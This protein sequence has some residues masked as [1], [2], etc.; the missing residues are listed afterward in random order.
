V[1][2]KIIIVGS[3]ASGVHFAL[4]L[5]RKGYHVTMLDVGNVGPKVVNPQD[6]FN[7]LKSTLSDPVDY[8]L[9]EE[10]QAVI[11]P[12]FESEYY[13]FPP[14]KD[15]VFATTSDNNVRP[16]GFAPLFSFAQ[17]GLAETW[18]GGAYPLTDDDLTDFP[19]TYKDIKPYYEEVSDRIGITGIRDDLVDFFP[20]HRNLMNPLDLDDHSQ[21]L[22]EDY[23]GNREWLN[24]KLGFFLG[25]SRA[26]TLSQDKEDR[27]RCNYDGR[28]LW[29]C[30]LEAL[31]TPSVTLKECMAFPNFTYVRDVYVTHFKFN[32][33]NRVTSVLA[34]S[35][36]G[37]E[38]TEFKVDK[39]I[40]AAGTLSSS[41]IFLNSLFFD[42]GQ[43]VKLQGLMDN[44]Q[45]LVPFVNLKMIGKRYSPDT[46]QYHQVAISIKNENP[47]NHVHGLITT[48]K[49]ALIHPLIQSVPFDLKSS[50]FIF[51]NVHSALGLVNL[52]FPDQRRKSNYLTLEPVSRSNLPEFVINYTP[53]ETEKNLIKK[54]MKRLKKALRRLGCIVPPGMAHVRPMGA[55]VHYAGT[56]PMSNEKMSLTTSPYCQ[57]HDLDNL[58]FVDGTT[59]PFLPAKNLTFTLM[60][61]AV[62]VAESAF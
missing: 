11:Y 31:Y 46:Y 60:A 59:F 19:L 24:N 7:D 37:T 33:G 47:Q 55:S 21:L 16:S 1:N 17:G 58:F 39:L 6:S 51:R 34:Q 28:C 9:G 5:L 45:I 42:T 36:K 62:R 10:F 30:P 38:S 32:S 56:I 25:R 2:E 43:I 41:R 20:F 26:A 23:A 18:T 8:F 12:D 27:K 57:S 49:T 29:G 52:N 48:L 35:L 3:G 15:H 40:L 44:R 14:S 61:N 54:T 50:I 22:L 13:G 53:E 4:S